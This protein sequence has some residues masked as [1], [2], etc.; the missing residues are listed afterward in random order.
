MFH[1]TRPTGTQRSG[2]GAT[3]CIDVL[4]LN[5][6]AQ[7]KQHLWGHSLN[8]RRETLNFASDPEN[9]T[10]ILQPSPG[11]L[12]GGQYLRMCAWGCLS[13]TLT[14]HVRSLF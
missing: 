12:M 1:R 10:E 3:P 13:L 2:V 14:V 7:L 6:A 8:S 11:A 9:C 4:N 5:A